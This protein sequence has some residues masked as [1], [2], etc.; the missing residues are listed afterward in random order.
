M[1]YPRWTYVVS[2]LGSFPASGLLAGALR[3]FDP[4]RSVR[5]TAIRTIAAF[6]YGLAMSGVLLAGGQLLIQQVEPLV[7]Y[8][9]IGTRKRRL[10][11]LWFGATLLLGV[12]L[13]IASAIFNLECGSL[14]LPPR[15]A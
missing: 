8:P 1:R 4:F 10:V 15:Q 2:S 6:G 11:G 13:L 12:S 5:V 9:R 3:A 7:G 14:C